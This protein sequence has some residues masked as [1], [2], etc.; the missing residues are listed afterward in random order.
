VLLFDSE[1]GS[2]NLERKSIGVT[3]RS[4]TPILKSVQPNVF[5]PIVDFIASF[6]GDAEVFTDGS[7]LLSIEEPGNKFDSFVHA[8][9]LFPGHLGTPKYRY[10]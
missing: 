6:S 8:I 3:I 7:H 1:Y 10:V 4:S 5:V 2:F 9:T